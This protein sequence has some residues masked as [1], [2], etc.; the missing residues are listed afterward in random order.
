MVRSSPRKRRS[1]LLPPK[2]DDPPLWA[3]ESPWPYIGPPPSDPFKCRYGC[4]FV[5][6]DG[7]RLCYHHNG[8]RRKLYKEAMSRRAATAT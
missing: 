6:V 2:A 5:A 7:K 4:G 8:H 1:G 3:K